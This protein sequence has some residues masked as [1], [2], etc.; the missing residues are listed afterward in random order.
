[1]V[2]RLDDVGGA[3][4]WTPPLLAV[5]LW[6]PSTAIVDRSAKLA[7]YET[8]G[9]PSYWIFDPNP[10]RPEL[11]VFELRDGSYQ[12]RQAKRTRCVLSTRSRYVSSRRSGRSAR[13]RKPRQ[14]GSHPV[15]VPGPG[16]QRLDDLRRPA[17]LRRGGVPAPVEQQRPLT[18]AL[19]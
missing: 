7:A 14:R 8:F 17:G 15:G 3:K 16:Q 5:E 12:L 1:V 4:F 2:V 9:V 11:T 10:D 19:P 13:T 18:A 6:S